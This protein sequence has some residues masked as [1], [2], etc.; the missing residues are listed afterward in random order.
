MYDNRIASLG[1][2]NEPVFVGGFCRDMSASTP[3][4]A[5]TIVAQTNSPRW[6]KAVPKLPSMRAHIVMS[7]APIISISSTYLRSALSK[8]ESARYLLPD[9]AAEVIREQGLYSHHSG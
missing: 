7:P 6:R 4:A 3:K 8:G 9:A 2:Y 1:R 5:N